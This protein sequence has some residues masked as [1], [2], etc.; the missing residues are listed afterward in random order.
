MWA[1]ITERKYLDLF[2]TPKPTI[3]IIHDWM[4]RRLCIDLKVPGREWENVA[5]L[6]PFQVHP[7][8]RVEGNYYPLFPGIKQIIIPK[9]ELVGFSLEIKPR[10]SIKSIEVTLY[11]SF[12]QDEF[13]I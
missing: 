4:S 7:V 3:I 6:I 5:W 2:T 12:L 9:H 13:S 10:N 11:E 1:K 8:G